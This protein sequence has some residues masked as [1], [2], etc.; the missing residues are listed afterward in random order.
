MIT[1]GTYDSVGKDI[2]LTDLA[3]ELAEEVGQAPPTDIYRIE[4]LAFDEFDPASPGAYVKE[5]IDKYG[6]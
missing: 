5:Q 6:V 4:K 2:F 3:R 1:D